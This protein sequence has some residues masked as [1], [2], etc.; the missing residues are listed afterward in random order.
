MITQRYLNKTIT[1]YGYILEDQAINKSIVARQPVTSLDPTAKA[2][3]CISEIVDRITFVGNAHEDKLK[4]TT[5][6]F[7]ERIQNNLRSMVSS[8]EK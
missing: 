1:D 2:S 8:W 6:G 5:G 7:F 4:L 3:R